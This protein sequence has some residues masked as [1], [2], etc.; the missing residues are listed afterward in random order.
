VRQEDSP[1]GTGGESHASWEVV[2]VVED[3]SKPET[4]GAD[5]PMI[6]LPLRPAGVYPITLAVRAPSLTSAAVSQRIRIVSMAVDPTLR[7]ARIR[8]LDA[9][10]NA[11]LDGQR[12]GV[13]ALVL[14]VVSVVLL[15]AAGI[16]ALMAFTVARRQ[17]EIGIRMALGARAGRVLVD[18]LSHALRQIGM[19]IAIGVLLGPVVFRFIGN[20][21][22][23]RE[24]GVQIAAMAAMAIVVGLLATIAPARRALR[25]QPTEALRAD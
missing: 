22:T 12:L 16:Y 19:G 15:S 14:V 23:W 21:S 10:L 8:T 1:T 25:V 3:L 4:Q 2:G 18:I 24:L 17:R 20:S 7:F 13:L 9:A 5:T 11:G 6:Y